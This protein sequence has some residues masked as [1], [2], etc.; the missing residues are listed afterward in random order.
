LGQVIK[1]ILLTACVSVSAAASAAENNI[2]PAEQHLLSQGVKITQRFVSGSG[3]RAI[4]ADSGTEKRLF[5]LTADGKHLVSGIVF[6]AQG[7]N[8]TNADMNKAGVPSVVGAEKIMNA[9]QLRQ[10]WDRAEQR[11][12]I[13]DGKSGKL[14][15]VFFDPNCPYCH[16]LWA[17][18][19][20]GVQAGKV[21]V[22]W[23]PVALLKDTSEPLGAAIYANPDEGLGQMVNHQLQPVAVSNQV[24]RN[25]ALNL[26]LL[27][28]T[29]YTGVPVLM[30]KRGEKVAALMGSPDE[31]ELAAILQ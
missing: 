29:G 2:T 3:M 31:K 16:R 21:Q 4:V 11:S 9:A 13:Q 18:L 20:A 25:M 6:D 8:V 24:K 5:Y 28:D 15:Y 12:W 1:A 14:I 10:L 22:R 27:R 23:L 19:R 17:T 26:L 30:F 7:N